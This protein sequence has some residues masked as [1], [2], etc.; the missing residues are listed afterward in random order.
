MIE[1]P[2]Y[3]EIEKIVEKVV[4]VDRINDTSMITIGLVF[5]A[6]IILNLAVLSAEV[7]NLIMGHFYG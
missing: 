6:S 4:E 7:T 3:I 1:R 2:V 5:A